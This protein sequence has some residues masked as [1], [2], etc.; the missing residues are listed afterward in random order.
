MI[1]MLAARRRAEDFAVALDAGPGARAAHPETA[2]LLTV[3]TALRSHA[4]RTSSPTSA[5]G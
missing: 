2:G 1:S 5:S 3:A 4:A